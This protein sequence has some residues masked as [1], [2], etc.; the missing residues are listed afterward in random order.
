[1]ISQKTLLGN[2]DRKLHEK[3]HRASWIRKRFKIGG[4]KILT[5]KQKI[6]FLKQFEKLRFFEFQNAVFSNVFV[7][8][9][10]I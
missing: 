3:F 8:R 10:R 6:L 7:M 5:E 1:M 9:R 2:F 4:T